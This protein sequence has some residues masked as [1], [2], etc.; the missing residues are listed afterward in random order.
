MGYAANKYPGNSFLNDRLLYSAGL[1]V[2]IVTAYDLK[3]R[4]EYAWN[5]LGQNGLFLHLNSE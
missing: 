4:L 1:G 3:I 2:D 5:H